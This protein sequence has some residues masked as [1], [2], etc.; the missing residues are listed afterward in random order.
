MGKLRSIEG[1]SLNQAQNIIVVNGFQT[2]SFCLGLRVLYPSSM[3][4]CSAISLLF[5]CP[6]DT[7]VEPSSHPTLPT[8]TPVEEKIERLT[9]ELQLMTRQRNELRERLIFITEG[10]VDKRYP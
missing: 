10:T 6:T 2:T 1:E 7:A 5:Y 9:T 4:C 3:P 8:K